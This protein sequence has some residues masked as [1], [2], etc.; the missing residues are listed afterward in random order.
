MNMLHFTE[1]GNL[2]APQ[3]L[4]PEKCLVLVCRRGTEIAQN[5]F[6]ASRVCKY[7]NC[8]CNCVEVDCTSKAVLALRHSAWA[9]RGLQDS[10]QNS[11]AEMSSAKDRHGAFSHCVQ[12]SCHGAIGEVV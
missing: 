9:E 3:M 8:Y 12:S 4:F 5:D 7:T 1:V 2:T 11:R 6:A 10:K